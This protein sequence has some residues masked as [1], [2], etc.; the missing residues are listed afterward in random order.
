MSQLSRNVDQVRQRIGEA[1]LRSGRSPSD[2]TLV[3]VA[4]GFTAESVLEA[5]EAGV[6]HFGENRVEEAQQKIPDVRSGIRAGQ[7]RWHMVGHIQSRKAEAVAELFDFVHSIDRLKVARRLD[8]FAEQTGAALPALLEC[9]VSGEESKYGF[10]VA[11]WDE[12][13]RRDAFFAAVDEI[14]GLPGLSVRGLMTMAPMTADPQQ[15]RPVF[16]DLRAL[17]DR[18]RERY[19][20]GDWRHLSMGMTDD[21]EVAVEEGAT[22]VRIGRAVFGRGMS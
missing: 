10:D 18:L 8:R 9:N 16:A 1:A 20:A 4:K 19:P 13:G 15:V 5:F 2:V 3:A 22:L 11:H 7:P 17:L 14:L 6:L 12:K 21:F